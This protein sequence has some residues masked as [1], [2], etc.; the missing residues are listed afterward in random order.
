MNESRL[1]KI[2]YYLLEKGKATAPELSEK[3]EVSIRTI[4][5]DIDALSSAGI[6]IYATQGKHGGIFLVEDYTL[7]KSLFSDTEKEQILAALQGIAAA[8]RSRHSDELL[9]KLGALFQMKSTGWIE[10]DFSDWVQNN[11]EQNIFHSIKSAIFSRNVISIKYFGSD[12]KMTTR[13]VQPY[14]LVFKSKAWYLYGYCLLRKDDRYF[15][16]TRIKSLE[17]L[18]DTFQPHL[19]PPTIKKQIRAGKT[20]R[21]TLKFDPHAAFRVY[22]EFSDHVTEDEQG[23]LYVQTDLPDNDLLYSYLFSFA[24]H[25]EVIEPQMIR[26]RIE[27]KL[28]EMQKKYRT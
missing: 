19:I 10:V 23:N 15:K 12:G 3:F 22:D 17:I 25:V 27:H 11:P 28:K 21:V 14:K 13:S 16:L 6:P 2:V 1:F 9:T 7:D 4:Y 26:E 5:R 8:D 20:I 24:D 18:P